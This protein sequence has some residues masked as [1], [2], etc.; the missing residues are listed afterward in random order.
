MTFPAGRYV[1]LEG[2]EVSP[3][4]VLEVSSVFT[5]VHSRA[6]RLEDNTKG[7][8]IC[9]FVKENARVV[10]RRNGRVKI[11]KEGDNG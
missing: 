11:I 8:L 5:V 3:N 4:H 1:T 9:L 6:C 10:T 2:I 7:A